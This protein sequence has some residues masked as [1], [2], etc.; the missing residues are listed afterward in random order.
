MHG[1]GIRARR[2]TVISIRALAFGPSAAADAG[3]P[4]LLIG[5]L[6]VQFVMA[7]QERKGI[8]RSMIRPF[9]RS[10][11][12]TLRDVMRRLTSVRFASILNHMVKYQDEALDRTFAALS[13]P[14]RR[15]LLAR[16]G[17]EE[18]LSV[19]ELA[20]PFAMSLPAIIEA[21]RRAVG[22]RP[23]RAR[24]N[25]PHRGVPADRRSRWSRRWTGSNRYQRFWS[26]NLDRLA[27]F[28][29]EDQWQPQIQRC[30]RRRSRRADRASPSSVVSM[31]APA[32]SLRR[33]D[34]PGK[35]NANGSARLGRQAE[36]GAGGDRCRGSAAA[37]ASA[38]MPMATNI[39][40]SAAS[41]ARWYRTSGWCSAGRGIRRR[42]ANRW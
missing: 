1:V 40:R 23:D 5:A 37:T 38:S 33:V 29:E 34:R 27:A 12:A 16:L 7:G 41:I 18:S 24:E 10:I 42:S 8:L 14:T 28:V 39:T 30:R 9:A 25:R 21:S 17:D 3:V 22:C 32:K 11:V 2:S 20:Q 31:R 15:A 36:L 13:D 6:P 19:S 26:D 4:G 35:T